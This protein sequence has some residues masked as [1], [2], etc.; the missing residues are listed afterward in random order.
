[1]AGRS[2]RCLA[3]LALLAA[4]RGAAAPGGV[5][6][7]LPAGVRVALTDLGDRLYK[8]FPGGLY[9]NGRNEI[10]DSHLQRGRAAASRIRRRAADGTPSGAG[11]Y[12]FLSI[13]MSNTTQEFSAFMQVAAADPQINRSALAL[14][15]GAAGGRTADSW[16][17]AS[18]VEYDRIRDTKLAPAGLS[19]A[20]VQVVWLK[21]ANA[22]PTTSL[23]SGGADAAR[24]MTQLG[25]IL[26]ALKSRYRNL[27][28]VLISS[29][30]YGGYATTSLNP[31]PYAYESGIAVRTVIGA[32]I[33]QEQTGLMLP[34]IG[35]LAE[36]VASWIAWGP[37]L[38]AD[39]TTARNDGFSWA[40][41]DFL[42]DGTHPSAAGRQ[43][44][45]VK[46]VQF[47]KTTAFTRCWFVTGATC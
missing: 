39:G 27:E 12:V 32:Q 33:G 46:L 14:V 4:C 21:V 5:D 3:S 24:L 41:S 30:T 44:V 15:D 9:P 29:R 19:E 35:N 47:L 8:G 37:Y 16:T 11:R 17:A 25:Q 31:E 10:P 23:P 34:A 6:Q 45:A 1:M 13:G 40:R 26:R 38:W 43:K 7:S 20:Q 2:G 36:S 28:Q 42:E 18:S 22:N